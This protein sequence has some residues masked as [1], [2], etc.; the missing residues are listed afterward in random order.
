MPEAPGEKKKNLHINKTAA[1]ILLFIA[2]AE[3]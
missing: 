3:L 1:K 2:E